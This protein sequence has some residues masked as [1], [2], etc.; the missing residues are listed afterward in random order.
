M[1]QTQT[2]A[3][4]MK[5]TGVRKMNHKHTQTL[6]TKRLVLRRLQESDGKAMFENWTSD[7][8][9]ATYTSWYA[10][11]TEQDSANFIKMHLDNYKNPD[12]YVWGI[13]YEDTLIGTIAVVK[14]EKDSAELG[15]VLSQAYWGQNITTE[16][17]LAVIKFLFETVGYQKITAR[18]DVQNH[19][20]GK[21][22]EKLGMKQ[23]KTIKNTIKR[24]D[25]SLGDAVHYELSYD[26][27]LK[28]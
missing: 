2:N 16:A 28:R 25:G 12:H 3:P 4:I 9:V 10:H 14:S 11:Q 20:S 15:Y 17:G 6:T 22:M 24:K 23:L 26:A 7:P 18:H 21:V 19:A 1:F 8:K 13:T 5:A 27:Y